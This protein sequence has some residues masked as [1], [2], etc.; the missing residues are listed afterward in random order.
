MAEMSFEIITLMEN[1][2]PRDC[3]AAEHG[4]SLLIQGEWLRELY[5]TGASPRFLKN[6]AALQ[7]PL[8]P[9]DALVFSHGHY[10]HTG[11]AAALL[12]AP[13]RP[14][15]IYLGEGFFTTRYSKKQDGLM[16]IGAA[17]SRA[18][19]EGAGVPCRQVRE[20]P[21]SLGKGL[22]LLSGFTPTQPFEGP[23]PTLLRQEETGLIPDPF[24]DEVAVVL[25]AGRELALISGCS[26]VGILSMCHR[27]AQQFGRPVTTFI[28]GTHLMA[29]GE[30][31]I[32]H[33][34]A[35]LKEWGLERLGACHCNGERA[36]VYFQE[37]FPGFFQNHV[38]TRVTVG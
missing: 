23:I 21:V 11:G 17:V 9:L 24:G 12:T 19:L 4:L 20:E 13:V 29:A 37:H 32:A 2:T 27:V 7:V 3:L 34:C 10:D 22:W 36:A 30:E 1:G 38:G 25:E 15:A 26:H 28:G 14:G 6:A 31:R 8:K 18:A 35:Q 33:T 16:E 5:D